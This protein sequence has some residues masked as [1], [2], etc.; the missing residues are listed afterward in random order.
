M[1]PVI[2]QTFDDL[3]PDVVT[4][5]IEHGRKID[6]I[7]MLIA[8]VL[9]SIPAPPAEGKAPS[10]TGRYRGL[11][12]ESKAK[13]ASLAYFV[14]QLGNFATFSFIGTWLSDQ[15][16]LSVAGVGAVLLFLGLGNTLSSFFGSSVVQRMGEEARSF[17]GW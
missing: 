14:F 7:N 12:R 1:L 16:G 2:G 13:K 9:P 17:W 5:R 4:E 6:F 11:L 3:E 15:F 8:L 10:M